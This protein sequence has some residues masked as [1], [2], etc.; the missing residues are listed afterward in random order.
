MDQTPPLDRRRLSQGSSV[1][2]DLGTLFALG[3]D[4]FGH[5][6]KM[7]RSVQMAVEQLSKLLAEAKSLKTNDAN[8]TS[9]LTLLRDQ[10]DTVDRDLETFR[11]TVEG[12]STIIQEIS[13][14]ERQILASVVETLLDVNDSLESLKA[15][16]VG[17]NTYVKD[18]PCPWRADAEDMTA[19]ERVNALTKIARLVP[20]LEMIL[21]KAADREGFVTEPGEVPKAKYWAK[22]VLDRFRDALIAAFFSAIASGVIALLAFTYYFGS[23]SVVAKAREDKQAEMIQR[24]QKLEDEKAALERQLRS[25]TD[26]RPGRQLRPGQAPTVYDR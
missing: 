19:E 3:D 18:H 5:V 1:K 6:M 16:V 7:S 26:P 11:E 21:T 10:V 23:K 15:S 12:H 17:L 13:T 22:K 8:V 25:Y 4:T 9:E 20:T 24:L 2:D 14:S